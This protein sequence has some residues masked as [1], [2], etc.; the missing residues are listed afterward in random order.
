MYKEKK[1]ARFQEVIEAPSN[2]VEGRD[3]GG[4]AA[5]FSHT[6]T[7]TQERAKEMHGHTHTDTHT[8]CTGYHIITVPIVAPRCSLFRRL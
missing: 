5:K 3:G 6:H 1:K 8:L 7:H 4:R 2:L